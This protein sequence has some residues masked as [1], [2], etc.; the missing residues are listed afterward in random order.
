[1]VNVLIGVPAATPQYYEERMEDLLNACLGSEETGVTFCRCTD[2]FL[3]KYSRHEAGLIIVL[4][5]LR[6]D[7]GYSGAVGKRTGTEKFIVIVPNSCKGNPT[8]LSL[9]RNG[10][11]NI[12]FQRDFTPGCVARLLQANRTLDDVMTYCGVDF[13]PVS[14][15]QVPDVIPG[16]VPAERRSG[17]SIR[18]KYLGDGIGLIQLLGKDVDLLDLKGVE[19]TEYDVGLF[20]GCD[21]TDE[22]R[23]AEMPVRTYPLEPD[24]VD[25][26]KDTLK[27]RFVKMGLLFFNGI[28]D[29]SFS[30]EEVRKRVLEELE[31]L[32]ITG[33]KAEMVLE[34]FLRDVNSYG[35]IDQLIL[36]PDV[37]D[38]RLMNK[39]TIN[40]QCM[41]QWFRTNVRFRTK[42]EY[43]SWILHICN[44]NNVPFNLAA[45]DVVFPDE[46][47]FAG[48]AMLRNSFTNSNLNVDRNCSGHI[49]I[50]RKI[51]K[52]ADDLIA[53]GFLTKA[54]ASL[55]ANCARQRKSMIICGGSG[56]GKTVL[57]N[58][59]IEYLPRDICGEIV[60][61]SSELF[62]PNHLNIKSSNSI[63]GKG[64]DSQVNYNLK[65]LSEK[66]LLR[67]TEVFINGEIKGDEAADFYTASRTTTVYTTLHADNCFGAIP[68]CAELVL[69]AGGRNVTREDVVSVL[70]RTISMVVY[71]ENYKVK[72]IAEVKGYDER[73]H[74]VRYVLYDFN[75]KEG[76]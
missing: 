60:Q 59:L 1:M 32:K 46:R 73:E 7:S 27:E 50:T 63:E 25:K 19:E 76:D 47:S 41:G 65:A 15:M 24:W 31:H 75:A 49:R 42:K 4:D 16:T 10:Y 12:L 14:A 74:D 67:N 33:D 26:C 52:M 37:S 66:A 69:A 39:D 11:Y 22:E 29:A 30:E 62:A 40:V 36:D 5:D 21:M 51:K 44:K 28:G 43:E 55:L 35:R 71:C 48:V 56:S 6:V 13:H 3:Q 53:D 61:E 8:L 20:A 64:T 2:D 9:I 38:V 18:R 34:S 58:F 54:Q 72:Q 45:A 68:R 17:S 57:L 70:A 23:S